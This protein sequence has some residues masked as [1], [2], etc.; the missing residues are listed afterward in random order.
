MFSLK[1]A[2]AYAPDNNSHG[3]YFANNALKAAPR[4]N[5]VYPLAYINPKIYCYYTMSG[6]Y[7]T[8]KALEG[9]NFWNNGPTRIGV[10]LVLPF[11]NGSDHGKVAPLSYASSGRRKR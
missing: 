2:G 3:V 1:K 7:A 8:P 10:R 11:T 5:T 9:G 4:T 6:R